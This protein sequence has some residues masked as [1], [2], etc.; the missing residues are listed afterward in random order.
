MFK[1]LESASWPHSADICREIIVP[2][3]EQ[4][5]TSVTLTAWLKQPG[6]LISMG[7]PVA[8]VETDKVTVEIV[9]PATGVFMEITRQLNETLRPGESIGLIRICGADE[10]DFV[11]PKASHQDEYTPAETNT[12]FKPHS[13][14]HKIVA[15]RVS[16]SL[17]DAAH[18]TSIFEAD[19][20]RVFADKEL[21]RPQGNS[22]PSYGAYILFAAVAAVRDVPEINSRYH[23]EGLEIL[24]EVN[25][26]VITAID[27]ND[28]VVPILRN[29]QSLNFQALNEELR[30]LTQKARSGQLLKNDITGGTFSVSN[31]G[32]SG[33]LMASPIVIFPPQVAVLGVGK[34][35]KRPIV[36]SNGD[37]ERIVAHPMVYLTLT[38]DHRAINGARSN[39]YM[40][41]VCEILENW[42]NAHVGVMNGQ[43]SEN[44]EKP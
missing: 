21:C 35:Q 9:S 10:N 41:R 29:A 33:S 16:A 18:V 6:E 15:E 14:K 42:P 19:M 38:I 4:T 27:K 7:E 26:G 12:L 30:Q 3:D 1:G 8:E 40:T 32:V 36:F 2:E 25:L 23:H 43:T 5:G 44:R 34:I 28:L 37:S 20:S 11:T 39:A 31:H 22:G 17:K 24:P 13:A